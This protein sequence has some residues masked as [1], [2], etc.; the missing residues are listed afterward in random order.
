MGKLRKFGSHG[1]QIP[2]METKFP[3]WGPTSISA[4]ISE[5][6]VQTKFQMF[7]ITSDVPCDMP[8]L[9]SS[10]QERFAAANQDVLSLGPLQ[11]THVPVG[12]H[13]G[14]P[15]PL[16]QPQ[17]P[18]QQQEMLQQPQF[19]MHQHVLP[20]PSLEPVT[21]QP[22]LFDQ[23]Q[24]LQLTAAV[25]ILQTKSGLVKRL[26]PRA[27]PGSVWRVDDR[28]TNFDTWK[29]QMYNWVQPSGTQPR[30]NGELT[31]HVFFIRTKEKQ[32]KGDSRLEKQLFVPVV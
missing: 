13:P 23:H 17:L 27:P 14:Q 5:Y 10:E 29:S 15:P 31:R 19:G 9:A 32:K 25:S 24:A 3:K 8:I 18:P 21:L 2:Q 26:P 20:A 1:D 22:V 7:T 6:Q 30:L 4:N 12:L 28:G 16:R 11:P